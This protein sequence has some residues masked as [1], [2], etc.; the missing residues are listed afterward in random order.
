MDS[1]KTITVFDPPVADAG[2]DVSIVLVAPVSSN[3]SNRSFLPMAANNKFYV[4]QS[5]NS[6][7]KPNEYR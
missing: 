6:Y 2:P 3:S 1:T 5:T 4:N 7:S